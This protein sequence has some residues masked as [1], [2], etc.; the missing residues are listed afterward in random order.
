[1]AEPVQ[2]DTCMLEL[3]QEYFWGVMRRCAAERE[4]TPHSPPAYMA[5]VGTNSRR[6]ELKLQ[7]NMLSAR[8]AVIAQWHSS[9]CGFHFVP[10][11]WRVVRKFT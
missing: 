2:G 7:S 10:F 5:I 9:I 1:M 4:C 3:T 6:N 8:Q 11:H